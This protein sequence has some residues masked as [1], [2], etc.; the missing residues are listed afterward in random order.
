MEEY[1]TKLGPGYYRLDVPKKGENDPAE[2]KRW[3]DKFNAYRREAEEKTAREA[4]A[5]SNQTALFKNSL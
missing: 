2:V 4:L 5:Q 1:R 3:K